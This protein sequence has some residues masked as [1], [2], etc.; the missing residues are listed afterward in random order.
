MKKLV[1]EH[2]EAK[3]VYGALA[4]LGWSPNMFYLC[5]ITKDL[6]Q[7]HFDRNRMDAC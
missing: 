6:K 2:T 3:P 5:F 1:Q 7:P 4:R